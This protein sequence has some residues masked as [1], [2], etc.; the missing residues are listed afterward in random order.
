LAGLTELAH[1]GGD[2]VNKK[3]K[4]ALRKRRKKQGKKIPLR[5]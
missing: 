5:Y 1:R 3:N 2:R 4:I